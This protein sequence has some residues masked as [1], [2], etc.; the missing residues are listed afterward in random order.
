[1]PARKIHTNTLKKEKEKK[2]MAEPTARKS[3]PKP[4]RESGVGRQ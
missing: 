2:H 3:K 1:M 4:K